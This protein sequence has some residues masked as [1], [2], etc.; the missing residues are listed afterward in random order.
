VRPRG[1]AEAAALVVDED[2]FLSDDDFVSDDDFL[3]EELLDDESELLELFDSD[4][5][6][7]GF[8]PRLSF[9]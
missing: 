5:D 3:S 8:E 4:F 2:D 6:S 7:E 1:Y 9:L